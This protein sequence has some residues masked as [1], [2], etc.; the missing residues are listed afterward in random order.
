[1]RKVARSQIYPE[2]F[3]ELVLT[4]GLFCDTLLSE[5]DE[6]SPVISLFEIDAVLM[7]APS[8]I[9]RIMGTCRIFH[10]F[11]IVK[12]AKN[13]TSPNIRVPKYTSP[14]I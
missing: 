8:P 3:I 14:N 12:C 1:M 5:G 6:A 4:V 9:F 7:E 2:G 13:G 10:V 11:E